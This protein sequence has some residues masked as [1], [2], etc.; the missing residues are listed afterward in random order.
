M[1]SQALVDASKAAMAKDYAGALALLEGTIEEPERS[2][3]V[4]QNILG[5][6]LWKVG[7]LDEASAC[8][9]ALAAQPGASAQ[10]AGNYRGVRL[11]AKVAA[12]TAANDANG[13][14][15]PGDAAAAA[16]CAARYEAVDLEDPCTDDIRFHALYNAGLCRLDAGD[17]GRA[18][19]CFEAA[20]QAKP[21][22]A[23]AWHNLGEALRLLG[24][25][26]GAAHAFGEAKARG[27]GGG[28]VGG[29]SDDEVAD[30]AGR[31][32]VES[33]LQ[34]GRYADALAALG[35][36]F[37]AGSGEGLIEPLYW[38]GLCR[39][40]TGDAAAAADD[41]EK[42][43]VLL[44]KQTHPI[45]PLAG[46]RGPLFTACARRG[47]A[48]LLDGNDAAAALPYFEK[49]VGAVDDA[50]AE[51]ATARLN[52]GICRARTG[53]GAGAAA[54]LRQLVDEGRGPPDRAGH[55]LGSV[56]LDGGDYAAAK[57]AYAAATAD[58]SK[59]RDPDDADGLHN[60]G[61]CCYK[62]GDLYAARVAFA[63]SLAMRRD[64]E[65]SVRAVK[66]IDALIA[67]RER[68]EDAALGALA[69]DW[70]ACAALGEDEAPAPSDLDA[71]YLLLRDRLARDAAEPLSGVKRGGTEEGSL[72]RPFDPAEL[73]EVR[74]ADDA[75]R[76][77]FRALR[78]VDK[79]R[80]SAFSPRDPALDDALAGHKAAAKKSIAEGEAA[81]R[82]DGPRGEAARTD[83]A[84]A[85]EAVRDVAARGDAAARNNAA[86][87]RDAERAALADAAAAVDGAV[88]AAAAAV[89]AHAR[90]AEAAAVAAAEA[91]AARRREAAA[92]AEAEE[93]AA[94]EAAERAALAADLDA[95][96]A[97]LGGA[98]DGGDPEGLA[99]VH[100]L[101]AAAVAAL[102]A[103]AGD[104]ARNGAAKD[105]VEAFG[106]AARA[107]AAEA[108]AAA[109]RKAAAAEC[110]RLAG[111]LA[112]GAA[113]AAARDR[114]AK[115]GVAD[116]P[117][118]AA[119][120]KIADA[121]RDAAAAAVDA[122]RGAAGDAA[123]ELLAAARAAVDAATDAAA[124]LGAAVADAARAA[125]KRRAAEGRR[126][127]AELLAR[128]ADEEAA[129]RRRAEEFYAAL[130]RKRLKK[131]GRVL[132]GAAQSSYEDPRKPLDVAAFA[133]ADA[134]AAR[135]LYA[136]G[137]STGALVVL[138][139]GRRRGSLR[140]AAAACLAEAARGRAPL[141]SDDDGALALY[142]AGW[143]PSALATLLRL[144]AA[145]GGD[146]ADL[147][148]GHAAALG[149][150][151]ATR[152]YD[153]ARKYALG[154]LAAPEA[155]PG[156]D[157]S[158]RELHLDAA[159]FAAAF[160]TD[161]AAF[162][163]LPKWKQAQLKRARGLF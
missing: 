94:L 12:I 138:A 9:G 136:Q 30:A 65:P 115:A 91:A 99:A 7:R 113:T 101:R 25:L 8:L 15:P 60:L 140:G 145:G 156:V 48:L 108:V 97:A 6:C 129:A 89:D 143:S 133:P 127:E 106:A 32:L 163:A 13:A 83:A 75:T 130:D 71:R 161:L 74:A 147:A 157:P 123:A 3:A 84:A 93:R 159:A 158:R 57:D 70:D 135:N 98:A 54:M 154:D 153:P 42:C 102:D 144:R 141:D 43:V 5:V 151:A 23:A 137:W 79:L 109:R 4:A 29:P 81:K 28:D 38:R 33:M 139:R 53:D 85:L 96:D 121:A 72:E 80:A 95:A 120:A 114:A 155:P 68:R 142:A 18:A 148:A 117:E 125:R 14:R 116:E 124:S 17:T 31:G 160:G 134:D 149:P 86:A 88:A 59:I 128:L 111:V 105:A 26:D 37:A 22:F 45:Y 66:L 2:S 27:G 150:A 103:A 46:V 77:A 131:T 104:G 39:L 58:P 20:L 36:L 87:R 132:D 76:K 40:N 34:A 110:D 119:A 52:L 50:H 61:F 63:K 118:F 51:R 73:P 82:S 152:T 92:A 21:D 146:L 90:A 44:E 162:E 35:P 41:L 49:A 64:H 122:A 16:A 10:V 1:A 100:A 107:H 24:D 56:L 78:A 47:E 62:L 19:Q 55:A 69:K 112:A 11:D 126:R 67:A